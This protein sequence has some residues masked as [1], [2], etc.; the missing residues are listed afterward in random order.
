MRRVILLL[1]LLS[2]AALAQNEQ[3]GDLNTSNINSTVS[4]NNPSNSTTN[5]YNGA[6]AASDVTPPPTAVSPSVPSGGT[7]S[8]LIGRGMGVQINLLGISAGGYK[9]DAECNRR[10]D[11]KALKE[12]GMSIASVARLCQN[13]ETWKAMFSSATPCPIAVNG[14]LVVGRAATLL[15]KRDPETFIPDYAVRKNF[16]DKILRIGKDDTDEDDGNSGLSISERFRSTRRAD[17]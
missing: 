14:K 4:S 2:N 10:R 7:E 8:C 3:T 12:Q 13:L 1:L 16:Y 9:Q 6:G 5:N 17:D 15:M 11:A